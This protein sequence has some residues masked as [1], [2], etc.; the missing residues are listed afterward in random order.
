MPSSRDSSSAALSISD[1]K[2]GDC[3]DYKN[4]NEKAQNFRI[5]TKIA[6]CALISSFE[7]SPTIIVKSVKISFS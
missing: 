1:L 4:L 7:S 3:D 6:L 5:L 2:Y